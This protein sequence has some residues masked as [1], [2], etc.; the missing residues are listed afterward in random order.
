M[1]TVGFQIIKEEFY[2]KFVKLT[3]NKPNSE[4]LC[5][6]EVNPHTPTPPPTQGDDPRLGQPP[7]PTPSCHPSL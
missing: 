7:P 5:T 6:R 4:R 1:Y 2:M 3:N